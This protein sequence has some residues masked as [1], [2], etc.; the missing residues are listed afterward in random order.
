MKKI[1]IVDDEEVV[2]KMLST[3]IQ[4]EGFYVETAVNGK[5][6][7]KIIKKNKPDLVVTDLMMPEKEG[8]ELIKDLKAL[9][10]DI[11]IIAISGGNKHFDPSIQL[12]SAQYLGADASFSKPLDRQEFISAIKTLLDKN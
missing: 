10:K 9:Y 4:R 7:L 12:K 8:I 5:D 11:K 2:L 1:T 6:A 3:M